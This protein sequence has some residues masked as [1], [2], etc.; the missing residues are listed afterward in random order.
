VG[1]A[2]E[3]ILADVLLL[4]DWLDVRNAFAAVDTLEQN[5]RR[6]QAVMVIRFDSGRRL[7]L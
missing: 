4:K 3:T 1:G 2:N 6:S 7:W 5:S